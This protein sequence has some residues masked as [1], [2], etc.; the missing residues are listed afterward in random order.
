[1]ARKKYNLVEMFLSRRVVKTRKMGITYTYEVLYV[2]PHLVREYAEENERKSR[3]RR[4]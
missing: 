2:P 1:M 4:V 3:R